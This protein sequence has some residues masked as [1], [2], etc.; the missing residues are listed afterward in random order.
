MRLLHVIPSFNPVG[1]GPVEGIRQISRALQDIGHE[2]E[3]ATLDDPDSQWLQDSD[4]TIHAL[5]PV[6]THSRWVHY[7]FAPKLG[8][9]LRK[10]AERYD[11]VLIHGIWQHHSFG[12]WRALRKMDIPY[13]VFTHG[14][15]DPWFKHAYPLK[16]MMKS[17][18]WFLAEYRVLRDAKFVL[19]TCEE[20]RI[21]ARQS[22]GLYR[23]NEKVVGFGTSPLTGD[24]RQQREAFL[25]RFPG[26]RGKRNFLF[27][28]RI[29]PKKGCDLLIQAFAEVAWHD[30]SLHLVIAGPD[31][32]H[33][34]KTLMKESQNLGISDRI[35]W[36]GML[37]G[38]E[39]WGAYR[40]AEVFVLPSHQENFG[41]VVTE[42]MLCG[43][44][45]LISNKV[46]I[47]REI[48]AD[49]AG[50]VA[51]DTLQGTTDLL[52]KW[53]LL[54]EL[55]KD[56]MKKKAIA[57]FGRNFDIRAVAKNLHEVVS[58]TASGER[59]AN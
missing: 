14:M 57:C 35:T 29:H 2:I 42:A 48:Q 47:W 22:F 18:Y 59:Y 3:I 17:L 4:M 21:L 44:P 56:A 10:N 15:L 38:D 46:N 28:S 13:Y 11:A 36:T 27:M 51:E 43:V 8:P 25:Q 49:G 16:H 7:Y 39:K 30:A 1:G 40:S 41:I 5:G 9:W 20:E 23:C 24:P 19:F 52:N 6:I 12:T 45:V 54:P 37:S 55:E 58:G 33:W 50:L 53:L 32:V 26:L 34:Q 31:Q